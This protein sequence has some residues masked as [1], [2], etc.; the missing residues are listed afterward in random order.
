MEY[1][2]SKKKKLTTD[3]YSTWMNLKNT[4]VSERSDK[5]YIVQLY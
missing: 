2:L 3:T 4:T 5:L 1:C